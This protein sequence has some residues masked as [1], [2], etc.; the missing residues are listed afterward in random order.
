MCH[1]SGGVT[2]LYKGGARH[3]T[4]NLYLGFFLLFLAVITFFFDMRF[5]EFPKVVFGTLLA[6]IGIYH[7]FLAKPTWVS[8]E[9]KIRLVMAALIVLWTKNL[10]YVLAM[11]MFLSLLK[12]SLVSRRLL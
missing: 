9:G 3:W 5:L 2:A 4:S 8:I 6:V 1:G 10:I 12:A 11:Q 7:L